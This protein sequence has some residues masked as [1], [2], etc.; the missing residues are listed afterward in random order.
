MASAMRAIRIGL[1]TLTGSRQ[2]ALELRNPTSPP[3]YYCELYEPTAGP[4]FK[5]ALTATVDGNTYQSLDGDAAEGPLA[6]HP[7]AMTLRRDPP[8]FGCSVAW[9]DGPH[10]LIDLI[11]AGVEVGTIAL[12]LDNLAIELEYLAV[13]QTDGS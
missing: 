10:E 2:L 11:P 9:R 12:V 4:T 6:N 13:I 5:L 3:A 1:A 7:L 8:Q